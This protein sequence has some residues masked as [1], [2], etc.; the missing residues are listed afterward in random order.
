MRRGERHAEE[1]ECV[2]EMVLDRG[3]IHREHFRGKS[4][5]ERVRPERSQRDRGGPG[6]RCEDEKQ[7]QRVFFAFFTRCGRFLP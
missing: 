7:P 2:P 3:V 1:N 4:C 5:F 6:Q